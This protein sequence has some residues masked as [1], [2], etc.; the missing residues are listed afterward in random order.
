M[1][2]IALATALSDIVATLLLKGRT[3]HG[4]CEVPLTLNETTMCSISP[5]DATGILL[6]KAKLLII[7]KISMGH[8]YIFEAIDRILQELRVKDKLFGGLTVLLAY[9]DLRLWKLP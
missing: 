9:Q 1:K 2:E 6:Q 7:D 4:R 3:L 8:K 5:R